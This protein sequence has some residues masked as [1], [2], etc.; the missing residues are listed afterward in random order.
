LNVFGSD[1][2]TTDITGVRDSIDFVNETK[3]CVWAVDYSLRHLRVKVVEVGRENVNSDLDFKMVKVVAKTNE[4]R[5]KYEVI[6]R[7]ERDIEICFMEVGKMKLLFVWEVTYDI[8]GI[9][10]DT[11]CLN[12]LNLKN[13][14]NLSDYGTSRKSSRDIFGFLNSSEELYGSKMINEGIG[15]EK[16][17]VKFESAANH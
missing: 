17:K 5:V 11:E 8:H 12:E 13:L 15:K 3:K 16:S 1:Y 14:S 10:S 4:R 7:C 9:C 2:D 6:G